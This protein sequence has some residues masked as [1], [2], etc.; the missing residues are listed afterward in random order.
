M[1]RILN[2]FRELRKKGQ[3]AEPRTSDPKAPRMQQ[4]AAQ[5]HSVQCVL[6]ELGN[7]APQD[8]AA[9]PLITEGQRQ[10]QQ[11]RETVT[12]LPTEDRDAWLL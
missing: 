10:M 6:A 5:A 12:G 4:A 2:P 11:L 3:G 1:D 9:F 7:L 8:A